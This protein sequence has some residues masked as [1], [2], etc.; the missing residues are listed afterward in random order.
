VI[1]ILTQ[2][3]AQTI[4]IVVLRTQQP[5]FPRPFRMWLYPV[6]A[7]LAFAGYVYTIVMRPKSI[8]SI[9]LAAVVVL[10]GTILFWIR[11]RAAARSGRRGSGSA[12]S[13]TAAAS[14]SRSRSSCRRETST[15]RAV[16]SDA[17]PPG[18][19]RASTKL[20]A[21]V[22]CASCGSVYFSDAASAL[23]ARNAAA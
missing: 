21:L 10:V 22:I 8:Q 12:I 6:P 11:Q 16:S 23:P 4:G 19:R 9:G 2:F 7:L 13:C 1:R 5:A 14:Q 15:A 18:V 3:L 20:R 17:G